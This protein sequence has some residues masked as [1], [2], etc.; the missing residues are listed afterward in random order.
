MLRFRLPLLAALTFGSMTL[1]GCDAFSK[2][3]DGPA[4]TGVYVANQGNF[5]DGNGSV[6][7]YDPETNAATPAAI[8]GLGSIVQSVLVHEGR[9]YLTANTGGRVDVFD[10]ATLARVG[11][12][13]G[14]VSP[15]YLAVARGKLY[16]TN[17]YA[18]AGTFSGGTV[19]VVDLATL[20]KVK[21]ITVGD[22]PEGIAVAGD[23]VFVANHGFGAGRT[24]S[25]IDARTDAVVLTVDAGCD[26]PRSLFVDGEGELVALC[27]GNTLYDANF[28]VAGRTNGALR[29]L[30]PATGT[31]RARLDL[32]AQAGAAGA[33]QDGFFSRETDELFFVSGPNVR[34]F[35]TDTH[36]LAADAATV[37]NG[38]PGAVAFDAAR[39]DL[40]VGL[41]PASNAYTTAG[42]VDVF[43]LGAGAFAKRATFAAGVAP[44]FI[45][46]R[47]GR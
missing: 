7:T 20:A 2:D 45:L 11:Q 28:N 26:G 31:V 10:A 33:G 16:V 41:L 3:D 30:D 37:T 32:P 22:N 46:F 13:A 38:S 36:A 6:S 9:L 34:R 25:V 19:S 15:R 5:G 44:T 14:L 27:T 23:R 39:G 17:L 24:L 42:A 35:R 21:D 12:V 4:V 8:T 18:S 29:V 43:R 40:Y 47:E 1:A